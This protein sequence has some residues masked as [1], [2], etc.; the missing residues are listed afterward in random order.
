M[1]HVLRNMCST[2]KVTEITGD[3]MAGASCLALVP[4]RYDKYLCAH[5]YHE[6]HRYTFEE[7]WSCD[8]CAEDHVQHT[9]G[10]RATLQMPYQ[11]PA[12]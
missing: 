5:P 3:A 6:M 10:D 12:A 11:K 7:E 8:S 4:E 1:I 9:Q 2:L